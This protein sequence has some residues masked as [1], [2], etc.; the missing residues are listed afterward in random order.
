MWPA[1]PMGTGDVGC[2]SGPSPRADAAALRL[3]TRKVQD[4][5]VME[6]FGP[7]TPAGPP[8]VA[9]SAGP[10]GAV[11]GPST[12]EAAT[13]VTD[14]SVDE[15]AWD[16]SG[17]VART[18]S[19]AGLLGIGAVAGVAL[20]TTVGGVAGWSGTTLTVA[21]LVGFDLGVL[22]GAGAGDLLARRARAATAARTAAQDPTRAS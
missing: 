15:G 13:G 20:G 10:R 1:W 9:T 8:A 16:P 14:H 19:Y 12:P 3:A 17:P 4:V 2:G 11:G 21:A 7:T 22:V 18:S 6:R 5:T